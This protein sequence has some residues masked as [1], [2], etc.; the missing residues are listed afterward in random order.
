MAIPSGSGTEVIKGKSVTNDQ[1]GWAD[2]L[3]GQ[4]NHIVTVI[5]LHVCNTTGTAD[6]FSIRITGGQTGVS[7][8]VLLEQQTISAESTYVHND[9]F[10]LYN[11]DDLQIWN[12]GTT[13]N[14]YL[15]YIDQDWT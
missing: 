1:S 6:V 9:K 14:Y 15:T 10:V 5:S 11:T 13:L 2:L 7:T 4:T 12:D 3:D 8:I